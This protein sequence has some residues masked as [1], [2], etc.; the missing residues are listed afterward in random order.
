MVL[1][2]LA[3]VLTMAG[4]TSAAPIDTK[5]GT[6]AVVFQFSGLSNLGVSEYMG[7]IGMRYYIQDDLALRPGI[8]IGIGTAKDKQQDPE[9]KTT[10]T[11]FGLN[12]TLEKHMAGAASISP[13]IGA[14]AGFDYSKDK[15]EQ[16][17]NE[18]TDKRTGFGVAGVL[19]FEWG[20]T[21]S[22]T[23]GGEYALGVRSGSREVEV[24]TGSTTETTRDESSMDFGISTASVFLSVAW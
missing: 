2:I 14:R 23:L 15:N 20:F 5:A 16:G 12:L 11:T 19:G 10:D 1:G 21:E 3:F 9:R 13:Y 8:N 7:G 17:D 22:L 24:K 6:K 18:S 4:P